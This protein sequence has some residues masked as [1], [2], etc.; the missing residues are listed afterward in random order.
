MEVKY[1]FVRQDGY[2]ETN[3]F[4]WLHYHEVRNLDTVFSWKESKELFPGYLTS[5]QADKLMKRW[6]QHDNGVRVYWWR[7]ENSP[8]Q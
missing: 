1:Y 8:E 7:S 5:D 3:Q 4:N 2:T 6:N